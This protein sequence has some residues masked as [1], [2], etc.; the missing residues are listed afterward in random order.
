VAWIESIYGREPEERDAAEFATAP[1]LDYQSSPGGLL[2]LW[3]G[4]EEVPGIGRKD[5]QA[6]LRYF[7]ENSEAKAT[8]PQ[9]RML[10]GEDKISNPSQAARGVKEA[11]GK[12]LPEAKD[13][14]LTDPLRWAE[15][16]EVRRKSE[17]CG[18][19]PSR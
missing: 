15:G 13:W 1:R 10:L 6:L 7:C 9:L 16:V 14:L 11:L 2:R 4:G 12:A 19:S 17:E 3:I 5:E 18:K 8:G